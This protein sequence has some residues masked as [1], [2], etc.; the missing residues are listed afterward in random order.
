MGQKE[1]DTDERRNVKRKIEIEGQD[2]ENYDT[3]R[4]NERGRGN[5]TKGL[6]RT[7]WNMREQ[8]VNREVAKQKRETS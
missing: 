8:G 1:E 6:G 4:Q 3:E 2:V 7:Y 5:C